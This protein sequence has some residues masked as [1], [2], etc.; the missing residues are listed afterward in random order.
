MATI[1]STKLSYKYSYETTPRPLSVQRVLD[2]AHEALL[3][4]GRFGS[5]CVVTRGVGRGTGGAMGHAERAGAHGGTGASVQLDVLWLDCLVLADDAVMVNDAVVPGM[6]T[7]LLR[8]MGVSG[9]GGVV[10]GGPGGDLGDIGRVR[11][12]PGRYVTDGGTLWR[13]VLDRIGFRLQDVGRALG[14]YGR[15]HVDDMFRKFL[16]SSTAGADSFDADSVALV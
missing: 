7:D 5:R 10:A 15:A 1:N 2:L 11:R 8:E 16:D 3:L 6:G 9:I 14:L 13:D 4:F 12:P